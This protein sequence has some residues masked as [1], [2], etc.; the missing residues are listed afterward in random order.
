MATSTAHSGDGSRAVIDSSTPRPAVAS[1][2]CAEYEAIRPGG[3]GES[4]VV[5][6]SAR[7]GWV[8]DHRRHRATTCPLMAT[9]A[10]TTAVTEL[11]VALTVRLRGG[12]HGGGHGRQQDDL[13]EHPAA[14]EQPGA[15]G[16]GQALAPRGALAVQAERVDPEQQTGTGRDD[17]G[18]EHDV[19]PPDPREQASGDRR[20]DEHHQPAP[21]RRRP[22]DAGPVGPPPGPG[23][24]GGGVR[25]GEVVGPVPL[26]LLPGLVA[27]RAARQH[28]VH[29]PAEHHQQHADAE[30]HHD[31][32][33]GAD[34]VAPDG[35]RARS[36]ARAV[37][38]RSST[39]TSSA[40]STTSSAHTAAAA[41]A[42]RSHQRP[43]GRVRTI[44]TSHAST[45]AAAVATNAH[46][47]AT[48]TASST[49]P[50]ADGLSEP[51][52]RIAPSTVVAVTPAPAPV[53]RVRPSTW[54]SQARLSGASRR[55]PR[56]SVRGASGNATS[57]P[58]GTTSRPP[59]EATA[60]VTR[61]TSSSR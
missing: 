25:R 51:S 38:V 29:R 26:G 27:A 17:G 7:C 37:G 24:R 5:R 2:S 10:T 8:V 23:L 1:T 41:I 15:G 61:P 13:G 12:G 28:G 42:P 11:A 56:C 22:P 53:M 16:D 46:D 4:R 19:G 34:Q 43:P 44:S 21:Q 32:E 3:A 39:A 9:R 20:D 18:D 58:R 50:V 47:H 14:R 59:A 40:W 31:G 54:I 57:C 35:P 30:Q 6:S 48:A 45:C 49:A 55:A 36:E 52:G 33:P 60:A